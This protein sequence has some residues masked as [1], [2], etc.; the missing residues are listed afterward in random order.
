MLPRLSGATEPVA[1]PVPAAAPPAL[2]PKRVARVAASP[3][4]ARIVTEGEQFVR[5]WQPSGSNEQIATGRLLLGN[6]P[7]AG[8]RI[9]VDTFLLPQA[10]DAQGSFRYRADVTTARRHPISV[11]STAKAT[12]GGRKLTEAQAASLRAARGGFSVG[13]KLSTIATKRI[14]GGGAGHRACDGAE[15]H[16]AAAVTLFT[17]RLTGTITD[18]TGSS[19]AGAVVVSRT[20]DRSFWTFSEPSDGDG[21]YTSFFTASDQLGADP[22]PLA[23]GV[24][25]GDISYGGTVGQNVNFRA[26]R[27]ATL[28][29]KL[30]ATATGQMTF[31]EA[32]SQPG[33][34]YDGL[35]IGVAFGDKNA[36]VKPV[37][38]TWPDA[39][40]NFRLVLP[41]SAAG[42][43]VSFW[44]DRRPVFSRTPALPGKAASPGLF[45]SA[46][47]NHAPQ[48]LVAIRLPR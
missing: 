42:K 28:D 43:R 37:S 10:T 20:A 36:T 1:Q 5:T 11:A 33:A 32:T 4:A 7:V 14:A 12:V 31:S 26:L 13:Y 17:Y 6:R 45:P 25:S 41:A 2:A 21:H 44:M 9:R 38:A 29:V 46:P 34:V 19:V 47:R 27:S 22:V 35:L 8:A 3:G 18:S 23:V 15:R 24:A 30:P 40:G 39:K 48:Q 16:A